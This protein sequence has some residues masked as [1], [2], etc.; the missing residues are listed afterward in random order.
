MN[1]CQPLYRIGNRLGGRGARRGFTLVEILTALAIISVAGYISVSLL[2]NAQGVALANRHRMLADELAAECVAAI[3]ANPGLMNWPGAAALSE[4]APGDIIAIQKADAS[5]RVFP[6]PSTMPTN[7]TSFDRTRDLYRRFDWTAH[8]TIP[9]AGASVA[10]LT[11]T[12]HWRLRGRY[13]SV[14]RTTAAPAG[15]LGS[16][17]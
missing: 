5:P 9:E 12:V 2:A 7:S 16:A 6:A 17:P 11:I 1:R 4:T 10:D 3:Q 15:L 13:E 14:T 8:V